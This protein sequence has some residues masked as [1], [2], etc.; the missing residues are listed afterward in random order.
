MSDESRSEDLEALV[1]QF[2]ASD[3][4]ELHVR[5]GDFELYLS[6]EPGA[7]APWEGS[8]RVRDADRPMPPA[9]PTAALAAGS[10][11]STATDVAPAAETFAAPEGH[12]IIR[13]PYL[14][15]F[16]RAPKPGE[17]NFVELGQTVDPGTEMCLVEVMKLF[18]A[19]RAESRGIVRHVYAV[20]G[21]MVAEGQP[22]FALEPVA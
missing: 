6:N 19:V 20:D 11:P 22:L 18:T 7:E 13:A 16:Y 2:Q 14:G 15:H 8:A 9:Q 10:T 4:R 5:I 17:P 1:K 21:Q 12:D 3:L